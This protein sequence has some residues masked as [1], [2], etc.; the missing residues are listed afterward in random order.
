MSQISNSDKYFKILNTLLFKDYK[1]LDKTCKNKLLLSTIY[2]IQLLSNKD[3]KIWDM[4]S[5]IYNQNLNNI[6]NKINISQNLTYFNILMS[7]LYCSYC[8]EIIQYCL[9]CLLNR[10]FTNNKISLHILFGEN[11]T[12]LTGFVLVS[13]SIKLILS[14]M[15][16]HKDKIKWIHFFNEELDWIKNNKLII[17]NLENINK[18]D[19]ENNYSKIHYK[20]FRLSIIIVYKLLNINLDINEKE[21]LINKLYSFSFKELDNES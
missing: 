10:N 8:S 19:L 12:Q 2:S 14:N 6:G 1:H 15:V 11:V 5:Y 17:Q 3:F 4:A 7:S 20:Y 16:N 13:E 21:K 9:P 18:E